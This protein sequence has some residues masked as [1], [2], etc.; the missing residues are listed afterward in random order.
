MP[1]VGRQE[2]YEPPAKKEPRLRMRD[3]KSPSVRATSAEKIR[4]WIATWNASYLEKVAVPPQIS[5]AHGLVALLDESERQSTLLQDQV[6]VLERQNELLIEQTALL[7]ELVKRTPALS[8]HAAS[9]HD[10]G[11]L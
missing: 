10:E 4:S 1:V 7:R 5:E 9:A 11:H 2:G 3:V 8:Q 6:R